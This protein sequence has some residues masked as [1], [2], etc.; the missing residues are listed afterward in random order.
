MKVDGNISSA[1]CI[2][3]ASE[4]S[5]EHKAPTRDKLTG[6]AAAGL[7]NILLVHKSK[8]SPDFNTNR[9]RRRREMRRW[10][11][12]VDRRRSRWKII[13]WRLSLTLDIDIDISIDIDIVIDIDIDIV[14][15][16]DT[17]IGY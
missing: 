1:T 17:V 13:L 16:I 9:S 15:D 8:V 7:N 11:R 4:G 5:S 10:L 3:G 2:S 6:A 12:R 14:I